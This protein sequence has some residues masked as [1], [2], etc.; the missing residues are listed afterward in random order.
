[1]KNQIRA[2]EKTLALVV[3]A[4]FIVSKTS[5]LNA[6]SS[7]PPRVALP[8]RQQP[9]LLPPPH[10]NQLAEGG[11]IVAV[12]SQSGQG[13]VRVGYKADG[14]ISWRFACNAFAPVLSGFEKANAFAL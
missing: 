5:R 13:V 11:R 8:L 1:V 10:P 12:F 6:P 9:L 14:R 4:V 7:W 3:R 2:A